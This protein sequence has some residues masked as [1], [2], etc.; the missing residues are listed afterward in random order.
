MPKTLR[1]GTF[2]KFNRLTGDYEVGNEIAEAVAQM[3][4][5]LLHDVYTL[6]PSDAKSLAKKVSPFRPKWHPA[7]GRNF[8]PHYYPDGGKFGHIFYGKRG[9]DFEPR[10]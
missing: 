9:E 6:R 4:V 3:E 8:F 7:H 5:R 1:A 10:D 2:Y